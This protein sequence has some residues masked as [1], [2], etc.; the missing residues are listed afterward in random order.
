MK[1]FQIKDNFCHW[2]ATKKFPTL[3]SLEGRFP[4]DVLFVE[5]PDNVRE[6]WGYLN[7]EFIQPTPPEG[8]AYDEGTG[9]FYPID[10]VAPSQQPTDMEIM[11]ADLDYVLMV[12]E[13]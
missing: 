10:E 13:G 8:W 4:A 7:G 9:T 12:M 1:I 6:G 5:A 3:Q 2:D 11:R